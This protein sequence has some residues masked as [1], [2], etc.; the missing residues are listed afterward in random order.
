LEA[1]KLWKLIWLKFNQQHA[2][3]SHQPAHCQHRKTKR[4]GVDVTLLTKFN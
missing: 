2:I 4:Y 3:I 1:K